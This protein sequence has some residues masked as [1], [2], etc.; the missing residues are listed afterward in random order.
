MD[1]CTP[2]FGLEDTVLFIPNRNN[3]HIIL[4]E[5]GLH[6]NRWLETMLFFIIFIVTIIIVVIVA[7]NVRIVII[8]IIVIRHGEM[9][10]GTKIGSD[11]GVKK[12]GAT[13]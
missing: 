11:R 8:I 9:G 5:E 1:T 6:L 13:F 2:V 4:S 3:A 12:V 10:K 7:V